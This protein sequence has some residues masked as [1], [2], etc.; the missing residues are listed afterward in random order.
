M[1][2]MENISKWT[3]TNKEKDQ[4][5]SALTPELVLLRTKAEISQEE[6]AALIG[7]SRQTY[8]A[9]ER[10][11]RRMSWNTFLS[12][13]LFY[14][15]NQKTHQMLRTI[16]AIP[17]E[18]MKRFNVGEEITTKEINL[19]AFLGDGAKIVM[20]SLDEQAIRSIRT[21][22]MV[23]YARCTSTPGEV[24]VKSFDGMN[25]TTTP[26]D[27]SDAEKALKAIKERSKNH[28]QYGG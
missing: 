2:W 3:I 10:G 25:F 5:I 7:I 23:E 9:I 6:L 16:K 19:D 28:E 17:Q 11:S 8:G 26:Y 15:C 4:L 22:I 18:I 27:D 1:R 12:L 13:V 21:M 14:D 24:V 20:D